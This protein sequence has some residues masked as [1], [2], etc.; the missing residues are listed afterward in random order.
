LRIDEQIGENLSHNECKT[1]LIDSPCF[2]QAKKHVQSMEKHCILGND[3]IKKVLATSIV[4]KEKSFLSQSR[5]E[6]FEKENST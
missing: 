4:P 1:I 2:A 5:S 6:I 3:S